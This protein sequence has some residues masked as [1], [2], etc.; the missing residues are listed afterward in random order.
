MCAIDDRMRTSAPNVYAVGDV[1]AKVQLAHVASA[2]GVVA[3]ETIAG[4]ETMPLNYSMM[5]R[6]T[7]CQ[8]QVASFG[9]TEHQA[10][11]AG[12]DVRVATFPMQASAK[13]HGLGE[14]AGFIKVLAD[15][16]HGELLGAH[17]VGADVSELLPELTAAQL[18]DLTA[19]ELARNV[20][21]HPTLGE[22]LQECLHALSGHAIN[23]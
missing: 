8:P 21:T 4:V 1:T 16:A 11:G 10:R 17:L 20:H 23:L 14:R 3:A 5:P 13:A 9:H 19:M 2:Q 12:Y 15:A 18:W 22:G 7:F 6:V